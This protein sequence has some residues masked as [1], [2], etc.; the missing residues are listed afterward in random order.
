MI[1]NRSIASRLAIAVVVALGTPIAVLPTHA[2]AQSATPQGAASGPPN[3]SVLPYP[4]P[5]FKGVIGRTTA[6]L[7][8]RLSSAGEGAR[9]RAEHS[10][11]PDR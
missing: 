10:G 9:R 4:D 2:L 1:M 5:T 6:E 3:V 8:A 7:E 11:H